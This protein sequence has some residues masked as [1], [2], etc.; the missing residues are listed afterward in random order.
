MQT[1]YKAH[2][3]SGNISISRY[4]DVP[5]NTVKALTNKIEKIEHHSDITKNRTVLQNS[6]KNKIKTYHGGC[7]EIYCNIKGA[8]GISD[9][10]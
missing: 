8:L 1:A 6:Q 2:I 5:W 7:Q 10:Y 3:V 9:K 4:I